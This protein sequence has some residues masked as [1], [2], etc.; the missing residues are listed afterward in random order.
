MLALFSCRLRCRAAM[1]HARISTTV[2]YGDVSGDGEA[3]FAAR[4]WDLH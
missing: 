4:F 1:A 2:I 3:A